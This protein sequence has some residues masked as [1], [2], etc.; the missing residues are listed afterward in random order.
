VTKPALAPDAAAPPAGGVVRGVLGT[1]AF[2]PY[3]F[4]M[5]VAPDAR[6]VVR[7]VFAT[8]LRCG[9]R[10]TANVFYERGAAIRADGTFRI[11]NRY[12]IR[13]GG[14][15]VELGRTVISGRF[16]AGGATG[17]LSVSSTT[18]RGGDVTGRCRSGSRRW[19]AATA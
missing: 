8:P 5:R 17:T 2:S 15:R 18:R 10:S 13:L 3:E 14:G 19:S 11:V 4:V 16:V 9:R 7:A 1:K 12:R 6:R